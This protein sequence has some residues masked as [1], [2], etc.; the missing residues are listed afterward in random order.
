MD[1]ASI[2]A[3]GQLIG[4][5]THGRLIYHFA[6]P[7]KIELLAKRGPGINNF[8]LLSPLITDVGSSHLV[9]NAEAGKTYYVRV[10]LLPPSLSTIYTTRLEWV[11]DEMGASEIT[12][13]KLQQKTSQ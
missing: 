2:K 11:R 10:S 5:A 8:G 3:N 1:S 7:G 6:S 12:Q 4:Y 13:C 9:L